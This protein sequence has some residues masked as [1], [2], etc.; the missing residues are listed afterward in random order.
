MEE[1][2]EVVEKD[3]VSRL[4]LDEVVD[5]TRHPKRPLLAGQLEQPL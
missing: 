2:L 3:G 4:L 1:H 5:E